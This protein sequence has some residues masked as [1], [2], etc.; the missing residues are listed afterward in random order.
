MR[1]TSLSRKAP[2]EI[3][4]V[5]F[6]FQKFVSTID[7]ATITVTVKSGIDGSPASMLYSSA[8]ISG[9]QVRQLIAGGVDGVV[10]RIR[11]DIVSG[12]ERYSEAA[13]L[14]VMELQA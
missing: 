2:A 8:Q 7:S 14:P 10:Y 1:I 6:D 11:V 12:S 5:T 13:Y 9:S 4:P 3:I